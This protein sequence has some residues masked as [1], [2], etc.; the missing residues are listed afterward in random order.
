MTVNIYVLI[1]PIG[2]YNAELQISQHCLEG[3]KILINL[4][5][6]D[7]KRDL[8]DIELNTNNDFNFSSIHSSFFKKIIFQVKRTIIVRRLVRQ[9]FRILKTES[10]NKVAL[11]YQNLEDPLTNRLFFNDWKV[12]FEGNIIEDG[13]ANYYDCYKVYPER[14]KNLVKKKTFLA[15]LFFKFRIPA[16]LTGIGYDIVKHQYVKQPYLAF[17]PEKSIELK[18]D[19]N[20]YS[21]IHDRILFIGQESYVNIFSKEYYNLRL[22][23]VIEELELRFPMA[24]IFYKR[25]YNSDVF[26][27]LADNIR[28]IKDK[29]R[30]E[31]VVAKFCPEV[32]LSF[33][34]SAL[35]NLALE[36][37]TEMSNK[38]LKIFYVGGF[39]CPENVIFLFEK[40]GIEYFNLTH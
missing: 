22:Q 4:S 37:H 23:E 18:V 12:D 16:T 36:Y 24:E 14:K 33:T 39:N 17:K 31:L 35:L 19:E 40:L 3:R 34:S 25:H 11:F 9:V 38:N 21:V 26:I 1:S 20:I 10:I 15:L 5:G 32:I 13:V 29:K 30:V 6:V 8:W 28:V 27:E 2:I 7:F